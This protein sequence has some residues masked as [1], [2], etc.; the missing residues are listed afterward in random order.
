MKIELSSTRVRDVF[1]IQPTT[2]SFQPLRSEANCSHSPRTTCAKQLHFSRPGLETSGRFCLSTGVRSRLCHDDER[3]SI[4]PS[5]VAC[6]VDV[7]RICSRSF[8]LT[9]T[10][11]RIPS[12]V[13]VVNERV[14]RMSCSSKKPSPHTAAKFLSCLHLSYVHLEAIICN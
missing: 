6:V 2:T 14:Q 1:G 8:A 10:S 3:H 9:C 12:T 13:G 11:R 4:A 5:A 7:L